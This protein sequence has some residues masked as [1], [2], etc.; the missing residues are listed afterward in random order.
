MPLLIN[1]LN[2]TLTFC[3]AFGSFPNLKPDKL[4]Y[5]PKDL[6]AMFPLQVSLNMDDGR[7]LGL[8]IR[9]GAE[10]GLG[11]YITGVDP[12]SAADAGGL[13]VGDQILEVDGQSFVIISHDEAVHILKTGCHLRMK[14]RD[15]GRQ[16][17]H[18]QGACCPSGCSWLC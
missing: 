3:P 5:L 16:T 9:G 1:L 4:G 18:V 2:F 15:V 7:S 8:M 14:V 11:I 12:G 10:Y 13:K 17:T 6:N